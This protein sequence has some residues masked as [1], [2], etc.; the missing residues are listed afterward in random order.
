MSEIS[1][2]FERDPGLYSNQDIDAIVAKQREFQAQYEHG[3][4]T[5]AARAPKPPKE[6]STKT[7]D[8]LKD[9]G[10]T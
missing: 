7:M 5:G 6:K 3:V 8:L 4:K 9:L 1:E 10:L 2:L